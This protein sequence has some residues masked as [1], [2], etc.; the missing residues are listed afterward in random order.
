MPT[1]LAAEQAEQRRWRLR[2]QLARLNWFDQMLRNE[3]LPVD[4]QSHRQGVASANL[5]RFCAR[6]V[7]HYGELF[8]RLGLT[9]GDVENFSDLSILPPLTKRDLQEH[10][11]RLR[12]A[13]LPT[14]DRIGRII[15]TSGTTGQ[16]ARILH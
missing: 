5:V 8:C 12:A 6:E 14:G 16:P 1:N 13:V 15:K 2:P 3:F 9:N 11:D 7:P 4:E 10:F